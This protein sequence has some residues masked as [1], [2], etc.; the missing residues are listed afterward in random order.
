[1]LGNLSDYTDRVPQRRL[2]PLS[3]MLIT[4]LIY[5]VIGHNSRNIE[6]TLYWYLA[7]V[8]IYNWILAVV[9]EDR[10]VTLMAGIIF[11]AI[12]ATTM[13]YVDPNL[14]LDR[15]PI[16]SF[17]AAINLPLI[18]RSTIGDR[19][20]VKAIAIATAIAWLGLILGWQ[21]SSYVSIIQ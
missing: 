7:I 12:V 18:V 2:K 6:S 21:I 4:G 14:S 15:L 10:T 3:L 8:L 9:T 19:G 17:F 20:R 13:H 5:M 16:I 1:M 11:Y